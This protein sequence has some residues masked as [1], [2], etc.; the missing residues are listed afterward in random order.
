MTPAMA[1]KSDLGCNGSILPAADS[2][3]QK[4]YCLQF[5][6]YTRGAKSGHLAVQPAYP[7]TR[8]RRLLRRSIVPNIFEGPEWLGLRTDP[9]GHRASSRD[10]DAS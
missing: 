10:L 3:N 6:R 1:A 4:P 7:A 9:R 5:R 2:D 8:S